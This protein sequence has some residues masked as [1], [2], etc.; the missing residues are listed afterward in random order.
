MRRVKQRTKRSKS[1]LAAEAIA[2]YVEAEDWQLG[3]IAAGLAELDSGKMVEH[4]R[5]VKWMRSWNN[6]SEGAPPR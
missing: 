2:T 4:K 5:A 3:E 1:F 6:P